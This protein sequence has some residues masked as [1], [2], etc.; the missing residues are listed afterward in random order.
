MLAKQFFVKT[1]LIMTLGSMATVGYTAP[2][3]VVNDPKTGKPLANQPTTDENPAPAP[4]QPTLA[5][6][7]APNQQQLSKAN[8][9]LLANNAELQRQVDS[10]TTQVNVLVNERSGQ[11]FIYGAMTAIIS[12]ILG[13]F[14]GWAIGRRARW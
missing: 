5:Q 12:I 10:L 13:S 14:I 2:E 7:T 9:K 11:L 4:N 1:L 3:V 6:L 8:E